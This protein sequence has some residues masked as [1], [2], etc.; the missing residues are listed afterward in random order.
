MLTEM[1]TVAVHF[2]FV[3]TCFLATACSSDDEP[4]CGDGTVSGTETMACDSDDESVCGDGAVSG[5]EKCDDGATVPGDGCNADCTIEAGFTCSGATSV[6][7]TTCGDGLIAGTETCDDGGN[8]ADDGCTAN[9]EQETGWSC[10]PSCEPICGDGLLRGSEEC[11]DEGN[12]PLD[13]CDANCVVEDGTHGCDGN[14]PSSCTLLCASDPTGIW[15]GSVD[16]TTNPLAKLGIGLLGNW[17]FAGE[18][19]LVAGDEMCRAIGADHVCN[20]SE[21]LA[22]DA[23]GEIL[24]G[25]GLSEEAAGTSFWLHRDVP[26]TFN[27]NNTMVTSPPGAGG[28]CNDWTMAGGPIAEGESFTLENDGSLTF[29]FAEETG[30][31]GALKVGSTN[32]CQAGPPRNI[33]CCLGYV[34]DTPTNAGTTYGQCVAPRPEV[35]ENHGCD[36]STADDR[37]GGNVTLSAGDLTGLTCLKVSAGSVIDVPAGLYDW[38]QGGLT[39]GDNKYHDVLSPIRVPLITNTTIDANNAGTWS[40]DTE[41]AY[42]F[43]HELNPGVQRGAVFIVPVP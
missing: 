7:A 22:A 21:I 15:H 41:G 17:S 42:P 38:L 16:N 28:R 31:D 33:P 4:A 27:S 11:D 23:K 14:E 43:F 8:D 35:P 13:G 32:P 37:T 40:T 34:P 39:D 20:Y 29:D 25:T 12:E 30:V 9:C 24:I 6:C 26:V 3:V 1:K 18:V 10:G 36:E 2:L 5:I 19:G